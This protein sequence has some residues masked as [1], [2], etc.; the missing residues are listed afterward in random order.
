MN[1]KVVQIAFSTSLQ[2]DP[3]VNADVGDK[4][5][6]TPFSLSEKT[7]NSTVGIIFLEIRIVHAVASISERDSR[8]I[9]A[10][11][12]NSFAHDHII[13]GT[14]AHFTA[15]EHEMTICPDTTRPHF[16]RKYR[17]VVIQEHGEMIID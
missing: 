17:G 6:L 8:C 3:A 5:Y 15:I 10:E 9:S 12:L 11:F 14:L 2:L 7:E 1:Y 16:L 13:A 4:S